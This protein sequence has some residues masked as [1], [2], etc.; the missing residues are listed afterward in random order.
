MEKKQFMAM[1]QNT[2]LK[3]EVSYFD[4][5]VLTN[6]KIKPVSGFSVEKTD[7]CDYMIR[8]DYS[9]NIE[10]RTENTFKPILRPLSDLIKPCLDGKLIPI[11]ELAKIYEE[12]FGEIKTK[13]VT[14]LSACLY[15][16]SEDVEMVFVYH[17][18]TQSFCAN[19]YLEKDF[20]NV[21]QQFSLFQKLI[22]WHFDIAGLIEKGEA[23][24][25]NTLPINPY[26]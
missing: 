24:D 18:K 21:H 11:V 8:F 17:W 5:G 19:T 14:N 20:I 22:E 1:S 25:V 16:D 9:D 7:I 23:I 6:T 2:G 10:F 26:K 3:C 15:T 4:D 12:V 13:Q